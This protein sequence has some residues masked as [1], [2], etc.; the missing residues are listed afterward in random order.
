M[1]KLKKVL[2]TLITTALWG[3]ALQVGGETFAV[4]IKAI[5]SNC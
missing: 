1:T 5:T 3:G 2:F 4:I